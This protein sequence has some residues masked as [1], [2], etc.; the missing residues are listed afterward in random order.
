MSQEIILLQKI[1]HNKAVVSKF[2]DALN[3]QDTA[4]LEETCIP[5]IAKNWIEALP[6]MYSTM[7]DHHIELVEILADA[8]GAAV[9]MA[10]SGYHTGV[11][12]GLP[13]TENKWT[14]RVFTFFKMEEGKIV[15]VDALPDVENII[16]Q[17]GGKITPING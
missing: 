17:L 7:K 13:P 2:V 9:K 15:D 4:L 1:E 6:W 12:H 16:K 5:E 11:I 3:R 10:T 8:N 14:N